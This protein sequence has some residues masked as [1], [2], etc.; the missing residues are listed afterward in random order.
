[1]GVWRERSTGI[2]IRTFEIDWGNG[3]GTDVI[4]LDGDGRKISIT[5]SR[6]EKFTGERME[7]FRAE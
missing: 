5:T 3:E 2:T 1:M 4:T 6:G 7:A